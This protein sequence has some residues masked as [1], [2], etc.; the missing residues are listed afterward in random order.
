M[1]KEQQDDGDDDGGKLV[2]TRSILDGGSS[3][4]GSELDGRS[5]Q[6]E[7]SSVHMHVDLKHL[8]DSF[9]YVENGHCSEVSVG[10]D[11][12]DDDDDTEAEIGLVYEAGERS[13]CDGDDRHY[14]Q[15]ANRRNTD[16]DTETEVETDT[17]TDTRQPSLHHLHTTPHSPQSAMLK[18]SLSH[19]GESP[20][21]FLTPTPPTHSTHI[22][23]IVPELIA[24][25]HVLQGTA[26]ASV[27]SG[28][29]V[30]LPRSEHLTSSLL[31]SSEYVAPGLDTVSAA[32]SLGSVVDPP[33]TIRKRM[34]TQPQ[35][36][37]QTQTQTQTQ[38]PS[39]TSNQI[40]PKV[41]RVAAPMPMKIATFGDIHI[42]DDGKK[43]RDSNVESREVNS[44]EASSHIDAPA[45]AAGAGAGTGGAAGRLVTTPTTHQRASPTTATTTTA[46]TKNT[47]IVQMHMSI[48]TRPSDVTA[49][50][51]VSS[52][53]IHKRPGAISR[54][55]TRF[56]GRNKTNNIGTKIKHNDAKVLQQR[57][58]VTIVVDKEPTH[59]P[60]HANS[61]SDSDSGHQT[62]DETA[63]FQNALDDKQMPVSLPDPN[64][65]LENLE[66]RSLENLS[67]I[68][69]TIEFKDIIEEIVPTKGKD[70][71]DTERPLEISVCG[72][73]TRMVEL[74]APPP[75]KTR[76]MD[77]TTPAS[78]M[79]HTH[80][81]HLEL[82]T[83]DLD[84][85][86]QSML[87]KMERMMHTT[88]MGGDDLHLPPLALGD[89][90][91]FDVEET[92]NNT[93][94]FFSLYEEED[95][96]TAPS[97]SSATATGGSPR[98]QLI[99]LPRP[100]TNK[101]RQPLRINTADIA[102]I[103]SAERI[104]RDHQPHMPPPSSTGTHTNM[105]WHTAGAG[106]GAGTQAYHTTTTARKSTSATATTSTAHALAPRR[107]VRNVK[108]SSQLHG[109]NPRPPRARKPLEL[110]STP[111][112]NKR[113]FIKI[114]YDM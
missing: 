4:C 39:V 64:F 74:K 55:H 67:L 84:C 109:T 113:T 65:P 13:D 23:R 96:P 3:V 78:L 80:T 37:R 97:A 46:V 43:A 105:T 103:S 87:N 58:N 15:Q 7:K 63:E 52:E 108:Q 114:K 47:A 88:E 98:K 6:L 19:S 28:T 76:R 25:N 8:V 62:D 34:Q 69:A 18:Y 106:S 111:L 82:T 92:Q 70:S 40:T 9:E 54:V 30:H 20:P 93:L 75:D 61:N 72:D 41:S 51:G 22:V 89:E 102:K 36:Q 14:H 2:N 38:K 99:V 56:P 60:L 101:Q 73:T 85:I 94:S 10:N 12:D 86:N 45:G 24:S 100:S 44:S 53:S 42:F 32:I 91:L 31:T 57:G 112:K 5:I 81:P 35:P 50:S 77:V 17:E 71:V 21:G 90:G 27:P 59:P 110:K 16:I 29:P 48:P 66:E 49:T 26:I 104:I 11:N 68:D 33:S 95:N 107:M 79:P 1:L 83:P